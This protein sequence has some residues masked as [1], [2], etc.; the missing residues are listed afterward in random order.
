[1]QYQYALPGNALLAGNWPPLR[2]KL[3]EDGASLGGYNL[4]DIGGPGSGIS[5]REGRRVNV[6]KIDVR[7]RIE[8]PPANGQTRELVPPN[9]EFVMVLDKQANGASPSAPWYDDDM[10]NCHTNL[11]NLGR[12][13]ILKRKRLYN[14]YKQIFT[15]NG[16][17]TTNEFS[18]STITF[19]MKKTWKKP[20]RVNYNSSASSGTGLNFSATV[21]NAISIFAIHDMKGQGASQLPFGDGFEL[22]MDWRVVFQD[23][24]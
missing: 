23:A 3:I 24:A 21:D 9:L 14:N 10:L 17:N 16:T 6:K 5:L 15:N 13:E 11:D 18:R 1:M 19:T 7:F 20:L 22:H 8:I 12:Y 2:W 4:L